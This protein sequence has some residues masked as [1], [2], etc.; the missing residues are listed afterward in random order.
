[1]GL[2]GSGHLAPEPCCFLCVSSCAYVGQYVLGR[3]EGS[4]PS[5]V[6]FNSMS[7]FPCH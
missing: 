5:K 7:L 6:G 2:Q 1:M 4:I 3:L